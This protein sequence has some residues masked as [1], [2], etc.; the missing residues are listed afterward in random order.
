MPKESYLDIAVIAF[1]LRMKLQRYQEAF[2]IDSEFPLPKEK[3]RD[4]VQ[5]AIYLNI[6]RKRYDMAAQAWKEIW[7]SLRQGQ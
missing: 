1:N 7:H 6:K 5:R 3:I 4:A 2:K